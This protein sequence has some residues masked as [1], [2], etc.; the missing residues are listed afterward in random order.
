MVTTYK[1]QY[2][3]AI[4]YLIKNSE[5]G[6]YGE[7]GLISLLCLYGIIIMVYEYI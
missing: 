7:S 3:Y 5:E 2:P 1:N 4:A 6:L